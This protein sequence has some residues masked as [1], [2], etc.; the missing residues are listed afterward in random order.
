MIAIGSS[1]DWG[2]GDLQRMS[3]A[4]RLAPEE[5]GT[6]LEDAGAGC[7]GLQHYR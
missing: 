7:I 4:R 6:P 3:A 5:K 1:P 2:E